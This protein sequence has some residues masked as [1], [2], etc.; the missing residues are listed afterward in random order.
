MPESLI[1]A[2]ILFGKD[3]VRFYTT[4]LQSFQFKKDDYERMEK[5]KNREDSIFFNSRNIFSKL[6]RAT[7]FRSRQADIVRD[8]TANSPY[9][10]VVAGDFNDVPNSYAYFTIKGSLQDAFLKEG[11]GIGRTFSGISPTLRIDY[12]LTTRQFSVLQFNRLIKNYSDHYMLV[13]DLQLKK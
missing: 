2:D 6:K 4:H 7:I 9:P 12:I 13:A 3:T 5:I 11:F 1:Q 8:I 10:Y